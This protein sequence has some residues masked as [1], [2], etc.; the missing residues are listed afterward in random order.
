MTEAEQIAQLRAENARLREALAF[1]PSA[2]HKPM[3][4]EAAMARYEGACRALRVALRE[5]SDCVTRQ[6]GEATRETR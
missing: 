1:D 5:L 2:E 6:H 3:T 4:Y